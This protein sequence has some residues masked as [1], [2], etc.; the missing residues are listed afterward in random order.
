MPPTVLPGRAK[1][2]L[3]LNSLPQG[4]YLLTL[5]LDGRHYATNKLV[6]RKQIVLP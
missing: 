1:T 5:T 4:T 6:V 3:T 2:E